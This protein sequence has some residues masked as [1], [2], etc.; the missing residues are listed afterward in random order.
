MNHIVYFE[1]DSDT[2]LMGPHLA[3]LSV[4]KSILLQPS[5]FTKR[6]ICSLP[7]FMKKTVTMWSPVWNRPF[8]QLLLSFGEEVIRLMPVRIEVLDSFSKSNCQS[9]MIIYDLL[10][11]VVS[12]YDFLAFVYVPYR[13]CLRKLDLSSRYLFSLYYALISVLNFVVLSL[14]CDEPLFS[15]IPLIV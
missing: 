10:V 3:T 5:S 7:S 14:G 6:T 1:L 2:D 4:V 12:T 8:F 11:D 13:S 9:T 15:L